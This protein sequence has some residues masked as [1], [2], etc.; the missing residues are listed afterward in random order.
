VVQMLNSGVTATWAMDVRTCA[1]RLIGG[2][3]CDA[4]PF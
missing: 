2:G 3:H 4:F 1:G